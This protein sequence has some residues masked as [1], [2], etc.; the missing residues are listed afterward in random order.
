[1]IALA[2]IGSS[3]L[4]ITIVNRHG[5]QS[6]IDLASS[7]ALQSARAHAEKIGVRFFDIL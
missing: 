5:P 4:E 6:L 2:C 3:H 7:C 1:L